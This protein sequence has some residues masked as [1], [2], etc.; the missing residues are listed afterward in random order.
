VLAADGE[1]VVVE[2]RSSRGADKEV[3]GALDV[4]A[5]LR[6]VMVSSKGDRGR[7]YAVTQ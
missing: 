4:S 2:Q 1:P 3:E 6:A 5:E 7:H